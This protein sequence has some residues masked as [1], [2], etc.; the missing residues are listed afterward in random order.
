MIQL[1]DSFRL[2]HSNFLT[3]LNQHHKIIKPTAHINASGKH[4]H[5][6]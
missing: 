4:D 6:S 2:Y 3:T 1:T 5:K